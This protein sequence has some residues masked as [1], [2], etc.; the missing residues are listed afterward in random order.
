MI[1]TQSLETGANVKQMTPVVEQA[2]PA[3]PDSLAEGFLRFLVVVA[4]VILGA[5]AALFLGLVTGWI[6]ITC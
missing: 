4:G 3:E 2:A 6:A 1:D 5:I